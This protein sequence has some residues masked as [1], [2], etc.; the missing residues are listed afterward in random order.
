MSSNTRQLLE[1]ED[2]EEIYETSCTGI[3]ECSIT[4]Q[5]HIEFVKNTKSKD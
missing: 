5:R 4:E 3:S 2:A 1:P